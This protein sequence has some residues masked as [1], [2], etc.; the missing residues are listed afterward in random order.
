MHN[1]SAWAQALNRYL[2]KEGK[3]PAAL[4]A[5]PPG[6]ASNFLLINLDFFFIVI[7]FTITVLHVNIIFLV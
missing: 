4:Q 6:N 2:L 1:Y 7:H 5:V 3:S